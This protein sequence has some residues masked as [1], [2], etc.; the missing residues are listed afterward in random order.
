M[1]LTNGT[2][3]DLERTI[4]LFPM[5]VDPNPSA[6]KAVVLNYTTNST[7]H[8]MWTQNGQTY[9]ADYNDPLLLLANNNET[10]DNSYYNPKWLTY[11]FETSETVRVVINNA[12]QAFHPMHLHGYQMQVLAEGDGYWNGTITNPSNPLR[13]DTHVLRRYGHL[14][15][16]ITAD[17]PGKPA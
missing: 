16:Q 8:H 13:R 14:V 6:T 4:P 10:P 3:V 15:I 1:E 17:N 7:G 11:D 9:S 2:Q 12:Y 5:P